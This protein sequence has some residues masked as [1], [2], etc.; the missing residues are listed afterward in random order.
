MS[1]LKAMGRKCYNSSKQGKEL[2]TIIQQGAPVINSGYIVEQ[3]ENLIAIEIDMKS[4]YCE[5]ALFTH[6]DPENICGLMIG[7]NEDSLNLKEDAAKDTYTE[8]EFTNFK[9][10]RIFAAN[11]GRYM[12]SVCLIKDKEV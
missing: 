10:F 8:I 5:V 2:F 11:I 4:K 3:S 7:T 6:K 1:I 12:L 9:G